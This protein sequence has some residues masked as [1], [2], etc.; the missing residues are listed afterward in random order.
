MDK[1]QRHFGG[2]YCIAFVEGM[3]KSIFYASD[4]PQKAAGGG[5]V[6]KMDENE[7]QNGS[8]G[9]F[10]LLESLDW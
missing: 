3:P 4:D 6:T 7:A 2:T 9:S 10:S 1:N 8:L 5:E